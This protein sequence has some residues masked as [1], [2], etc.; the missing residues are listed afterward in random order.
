LQQKLSLSINVAIKIDGLNIFIEIVVEVDSNIY[1]RL[2]LRL[3]YF[4]LNFTM[5]LKTTKIVRHLPDNISRDSAQRQT[6]GRSCFNPASVRRLNDHDWAIPGAPGM[7]SLAFMRCYV[8]SSRVRA[9][10]EVVRIYVR[11]LSNDS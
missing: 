9:W 8:R 3:L 7:P 2:K 4:H 1:C 6:P 10:F 11:E 5:T